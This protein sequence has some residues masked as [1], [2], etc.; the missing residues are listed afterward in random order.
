MENMF[1][2]MNIKIHLYDYVIKRFYFIHKYRCIQQI[3]L[4]T[5]TYLYKLFYF[6][7]FRLI[8][9]YNFLSSSNLLI[10][11]AALIS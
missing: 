4:K 3:M 7:I 8:S 10:L 1:Q 2:I 11:A 5:S 9:Y 6:L